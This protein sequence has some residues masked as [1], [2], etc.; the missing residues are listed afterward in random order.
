MVVVTLA[1]TV[2]LPGFGQSWFT[3]LMDTAGKAFTFTVAIAV[4]VQP[5]SSVPVTVMV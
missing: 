1:V 5:W 2:V 4:L 3:G